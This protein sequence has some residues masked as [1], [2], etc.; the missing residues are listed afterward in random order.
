LKN[1]IGKILQEFEEKENMLTCFKEI[2]HEREDKTKSYY[3]EI[4][5]DYVV[6]WYGIYTENE[7]D[8]TC[9]VTMKANLEELKGRK[10]I[11][12][13][14]NVSI[15]TYTILSKLNSLITKLETAMLL[16]IKQD[17]K[18]KVKRITEGL[19]EEVCHI[20]YKDEIKMIGKQEESWNEFD[21]T[22]EMISKILVKAKEENRYGRSKEFSLLLY[23]NRGQKIAQQLTKRKLATFEEIHHKTYKVHLLF[24]FQPTKTRKDL[25]SEVDHKLREDNC[26]EK[27][28]FLLKYFKENE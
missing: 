12:F 2:E 17:D 5:N 24:P 10:R 9:S 16:I 15:P 13:S 19:K 28:L 18:N 1:E 22:L 7:Q 21:E 23:G 27:G 6:E 20:T 14:Y 26:Y 8:I 25:L 11:T 4:T 3:P